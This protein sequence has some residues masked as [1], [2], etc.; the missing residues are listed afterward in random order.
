[1]E[2]RILQAEILKNLLFLQSEMSYT[3]VRNETHWLGGVIIEFKKEEHILSVLY[4]KREMWF[5]IKL[6][7]LNEESKTHM[8]IVEELRKICPTLQN[9]SIPLEKNE[10][11]VSFL[12][13]FGS[14]LK[15]NYDTLLANFKVGN[16]FGGNH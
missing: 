16:Y 8:Y 4:D 3:L 11:I 12:E 14:C 6:F 2:N 5:T 10:E 1:M 13:S 9:P 7:S 15:E